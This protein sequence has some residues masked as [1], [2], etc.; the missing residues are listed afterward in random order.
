MCTCSAYYKAGTSQCKCNKGILLSLSASV[1][2]HDMHEAVL[3]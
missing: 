3:N 2:D 1:K